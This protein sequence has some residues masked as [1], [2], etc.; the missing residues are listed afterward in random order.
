MYSVLDDEV[1]IWPSV[2]F[3]H[4]PIITILL[5]LQSPYF[6]LSFLSFDLRKLHT[7][8]PAVILAVFPPI[9]HGLSPHFCVATV[10]FTW[11]LPNHIRQ[12]S[13][14]NRRSGI[15]PVC[16]PLNCISTVAVLV[17][18]KNR[19]IHVT[20]LISLIRNQPV[21]HSRIAPQPRLE[22]GTSWLTVMRSTIELLGKR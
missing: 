21:L 1:Y 5:G 19:F 18:S 7:I 3:D 12:Q 20:M 17:H 15:N 13:P 2:T 8:W 6:V 14:L 4:D 11:H 9:I 16:F 10:P 22:L